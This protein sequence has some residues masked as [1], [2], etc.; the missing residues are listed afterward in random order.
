MV[1][2][3]K[4]KF[5]LMFQDEAGFGRINKPKLCWCGNGIR[6]VVP[7]QRIREYVY[8]YGAVSPVD[9]ELFSLIT[10]CKYRLYEC[11]F[12]RIITRVF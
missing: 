2:I 9:G 7:C 10:I 8:A 3:Y 5:R 11:V 12:R 6:P 4:D 1:N